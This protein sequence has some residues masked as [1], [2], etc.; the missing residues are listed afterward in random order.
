MRFNKNY[1]RVRDYAIKALENELW[2]FSNPF[3]DFDV[4]KAT[5]FELDE[6]DLF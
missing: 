5:G 4:F 6:D 3:D 1:I 2:A